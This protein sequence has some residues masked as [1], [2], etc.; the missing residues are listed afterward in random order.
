LSEVT[1]F[2]LGSE[3]GRFLARDFL[4]AALR[5]WFA[6]RSLD[7]VRDVLIRRGVSWG[8]YQ[9]FGQLV[10][11]D[12]RCSAANPMFEPIEHPGVGTYLVPRSPLDLDSVGR[13]PAARARAGRAHRRDSQRVAPP[14][15]PRD[16]ATGGGRHR[17]RAPPAGHD[18]DGSMI[19]TPS[20]E[21]SLSAT[22]ASGAWSSDMRLVTSR[23]GS[24]RP[25]TIRPSICG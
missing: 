2:D 5:P 13:L 23:P 15:R 9:T 4:V 7:E 20:G 12:P 24:K 3:S 10:E 1:G 11:E 14:E 6:S 16:R 18:G 17:Q 19:V 22:S 8:P 21:R 25:P